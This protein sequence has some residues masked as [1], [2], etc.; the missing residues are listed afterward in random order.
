VVLEEPPMRTGHIMLVDGRV[1]TVI[2][3]VINVDTGRILTGFEFGRTH[4]KG[5]LR[6]QYKIIEE[7][8]YSLHFE[9]T[10]GTLE[11]QPTVK[12]Y[13]KGEHG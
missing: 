10:G 12:L 9:A 1:A 8:Q 3:E 13:Q 4:V 11:S 5:N 7:E 2:C 6:I